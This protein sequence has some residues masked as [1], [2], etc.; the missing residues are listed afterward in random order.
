MKAFLMFIR[1]VKLILSELEALSQNCTEE[2]KTYSKYE[3][4]KSYG[5]Q[6]ERAFKTC[7]KI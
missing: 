6:S 7:S 4:F 5:L 1:A 3:E 2:N